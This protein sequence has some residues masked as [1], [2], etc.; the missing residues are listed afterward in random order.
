VLG[1]TGFTN[2]APVVTGTNV[3]YVSGPDWGNHDIYFQY[4]IGAGWNG[5]WLDLTATNLSGVGAIDPSIGVK[6]KYRIVCDTAATT[7]AITY[8]R[9]QTDSTAAAQENNLYPLDQL[10]LTLIGLVAG[11]DTTILAAGTETVL[12]TVED[13][14][15]TTYGYQYETPTTVDIAVYNPGYIPFF[16]RNYPLGTSDA[17][18]PIAQFAD[19]SY[20]T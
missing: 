13:W 16:I 8:I 14:A 3:T 6:L 10:T 2:T 5:S 7:N 19:P 15:G 9:V 20:I 11:S 12:D 17:T 4:D 18:V 1:V